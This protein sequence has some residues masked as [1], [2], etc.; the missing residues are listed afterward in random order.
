MIKDIRHEFVNALEAEDRAIARQ[1]GR[2][3]TVWGFGADAVALDD[4]E[5]LAGAV[6][7]CVAANNL[8]V[9]DEVVSR[10]QPQGVTIALVL[11]ESHLIL[12]TWPEHGVIQIELFSCRDIDRESLCAIL[13]EKTAAS[14]VYAF[15]MQ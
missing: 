9:K 4:A 13:S 2:Q 6:R 12:N 11:M 15:D 14:R 5:L 3:V 7:D 1:L 10:Y 8:T